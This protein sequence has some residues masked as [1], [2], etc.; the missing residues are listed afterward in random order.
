MAMQQIYV[1]G[2][3][4]AP[5]AWEKVIGHSPSAEVS[6]CLNLAALV[7]GKDVSYENLYAAFSDACNQSNSVINL[8]GLSLGSVLA[9]NYAID[10]PDKV[11]SMALIAPQYKMPGNLLRLQNAI[12]RIMPKSSFLQT[13]FGKTEFL[14]LCRSM[15]DLDFT[16]SL[17]KIACPVLILCGEKDL[18][19]KKTSV[20]L[21]GVLKNAELAIIHNAGHEVNLEAPEKLAELLDNFWG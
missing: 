10:F 8:C 16:A 19:N 2:L 18:F 4:Q 12:F 21:A 20:R 1:H 6:V 3:G 17:Q 15:M 7:H 9:L 5:D 13:G 14:R 11:K